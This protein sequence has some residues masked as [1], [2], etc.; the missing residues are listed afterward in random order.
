M[1]LKHFITIDKIK[2]ASMEELKEAG[3]SEKVAK[4]VIEYFNENDD[5]TVDF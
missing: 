3:L 2:N 1:L 4:N 5:E